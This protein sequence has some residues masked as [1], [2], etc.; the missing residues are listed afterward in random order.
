MKQISDK[1]AA[2][3]DSYEEACRVVRERDG[4]RC[5]AVS[6]LGGLPLDVLVGDGVFRP[7]AAA[8]WPAHCHGP[9]DPHHIGTRIR[10]PKLWDDP[11]NITTLCRAHHDWID[12]YSP[13]AEHVGLLIPSAH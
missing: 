10:F 11:D 12:D 8:A 6:Y 5:T 9:L 1:R 3:M 13:E 4:G 7:E 2:A